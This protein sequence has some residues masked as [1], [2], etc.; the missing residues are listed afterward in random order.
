MIRGLL[1]KA[2]ERGYPTRY[3]ERSSYVLE[4]IHASAFVASSSSMSSFSSESSESSSSTS[5]SSSHP[6]PSPRPPVLS[7]FRLDLSTGGNTARYVAGP[8]RSGV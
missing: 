1:S 8:A 6:V 4:A 2:C 5:E 3:P 7:S